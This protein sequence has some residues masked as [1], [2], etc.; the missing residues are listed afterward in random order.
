MVR[1]LPVLAV[2][3][4]LVCVTPANAEEQVASDG[5]VTATFFFEADDEYGYSDLWLTISRAGTVLYDAP[6]SAEGCEEPGCGPGN[7]DSDSVAVTDL[8]G[9]GEPEIVL[10]LYWGGAHCCTIAQVFSFS[11]NGYQVAERN[12]GN[13]GFRLDDIDGDGTTE[14]VTND[15]RFAYRYAAYAFSI[16]P[17]RVLAWDR[18]RWHDDTATHTDLVRSD[19]R[20][21]WRLL[22]SAQ[23]RGYETR[24]AAAAWAA[25]RYRLGKRRSTLKSLRRM[26]G[27]GKLEGTSPRSASK[28]VTTLDRF[29]IRSGYAAR[30]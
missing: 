14:A 4:A 16:L 5:A 22:K 29:L 15:D 21:T 12:L 18:Q 20:R 27:A 1:W 23:R 9:N 10:S 30:R 11:G 13:P 28:F 26:A 19:L 8:D 17:V 7:H 25:N 24:G 2:A 6:V 3:F